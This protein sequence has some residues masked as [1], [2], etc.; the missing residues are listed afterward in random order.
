[1]AK[2]KEED[3]L[4]E[5]KRVCRPPKEYLKQVNS[6]GG[7]TSID[8]MYTIMKATEEWGPV[9]SSWSYTIEEQN[10]IPT[11]DGQIMHYAVVALHTPEGGVYH[12]IGGTILYSGKGRIDEDAPKK[13]VTDALGKLLSLR[14]FNGDV[15]MGMWDGCKWIDTK[16]ENMVCDMFGGE[17]IADK[18]CATNEQITVIRELADENHIEKIKKWLNI[19]H[20]GELSFAQ[21]EK[22]I[23]RLEEIE[24]EKQ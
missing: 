18:V 23:A 10:I 9:G 19:Q 11:G 3:N 1:M 13:S 15:Y 22:C 5:W 24:K 17:I 21:A 6:R 16:P 2:K 8:P 14:G 12:H 20:L 4:A 7:F